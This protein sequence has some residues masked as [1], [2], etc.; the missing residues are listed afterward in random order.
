MADSNAIAAPD[1]VGSH[2][3]R[4]RLDKQALDGAL[5]VT[6]AIPGVDALLQQ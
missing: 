1:L 3:V 5:Q 2:E 4:E 6:G